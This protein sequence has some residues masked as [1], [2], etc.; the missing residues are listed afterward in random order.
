MC[1]KKL[2]ALIATGIFFINS[3]TYAANAEDFPTVDAPFANSQ[4]AETA[5]EDFPTVDEPFPKNH[6]S[7]INHT[8]ERGKEKNS[9]PAEKTSKK[10]SQPA[11]KPAEVFE[12][13][14]QTEVEK[15]AAKTETPPPTAQEGDGLEFLFYNENGV[16]AFAVVAAHEQYNLRPVIAKDHIQGRSTVSQMAGN[17][18]DI[19][20]INASYFSAD[21]SLIGITK[22]DGVIVSSDYF[23]RSA[24]GVNSDG[25]TIFGRIQYHGTVTYNGATVDINGVNCVRGTNSIIVYNEFFGNATGTNN[26]GVEIIEHDGIITDIRRDRGN[27]IIPHEGHVIS[28]HGTAAEI[29]A[30]AQIGDEITFEEN[31]LSEDADFNSAP[32]VLGAGPRLV[33]DGEV[34]VTATE[35]DFPPDIRMGRAPRSAVGVTKYGDYFFAVVD[36]RQAHSRGCTLEEWAKILVDKFGAFQAINL[37]GGGSTVL[38]VKDKLVNS[39]SDGRERAVGSALTILPK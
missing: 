12:E 13:P 22:I 23:N 15:P 4:Q 29:F 25:T 32:Y 16:Q 31:I 35:E 1:K 28:A 36:G 19:A 37:D 10:N 7:T 27:N 34:F 24:I 5:E 14:P 20:T 8:E 6:S 39:P 18:N 21:G 9:Q 17:L 26:F 3:A 33:R 11:E 2:V 30:N 38:V